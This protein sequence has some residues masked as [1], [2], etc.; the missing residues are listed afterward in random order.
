[1]ELE[2]DPNI[3][4]GLLRKYAG[5]FADDF[6]EVIG[7]DGTWTDYDAYMYNRDYRLYLDVV[8]EF[9]ELQIPNPRGWGVPAKV[10]LADPNGYELMEQAIAKQYEQYG[11]GVPIS[12]WLKTNSILDG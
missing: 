12:K 1:M 10:P 3:R 5:K 6:E 7:D 11:I 9:V 8:G 2:R 4:L